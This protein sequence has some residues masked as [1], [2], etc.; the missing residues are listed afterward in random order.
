MSSLPT[1]L[2]SGPC[3]KATPGFRDNE[4]VVLCLEQIL[5]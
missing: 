5:V 4:E 1:K 3:G 2:R